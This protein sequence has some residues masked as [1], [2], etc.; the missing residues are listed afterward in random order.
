MQIIYS[1]RNR[2]IYVPTNWVSPDVSR[3]PSMMKRCNLL[4]ADSRRPMEDR[5]RDNAT[6]E[7]QK[8]I[9]A[10]MEEHPDWAVIEYLAK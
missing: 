7:H 8:L 4:I 6:A 1:E 5:I 9:R 2:T 10:A 3:E